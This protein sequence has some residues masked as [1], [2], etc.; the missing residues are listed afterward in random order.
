MRILITGASGFIGSNLV[1]YLLKQGHEVVGID[2]YSNGLASNLKSAAT[3]NNFTML[4]IDLSQWGTV[5]DLLKFHKFDAI[6]HLAARGSVPASIEDPGSTLEQNVDITHELMLLA[7]KHNV[8]RFIY[9]SS[10]SVYGDAV[11]VKTEDLVC[12]PLNPYGISKHVTEQY[13]ENFHKLFGLQCAGMRFFNVYGPRQRA[14]I[15]NAAVIPSFISQTLKDMPLQIA[16]DGASTRDFTFVYDVC[17]ALSMFLNASPKTWG[18]KVYNVCTGRETSIGV[19]GQMVQSLMGK[20]TLPIVMGADRQGDIKHSVGSNKRLVKDL[21]WAPTTPLNTGL[22]ETIRSY[23][24][25]N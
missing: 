15:K 25:E 18:G 5:S 3:H 12:K 4:G 19:T 13:G 8:E 14:D 24:N 22:I 21:H 20:D 9:A 23:Q 2:N 7:V 16:G 11:G 10:S 1:D 17:R 6:Y